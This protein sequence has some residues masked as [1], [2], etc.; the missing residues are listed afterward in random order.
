MTILLGD[1]CWNPEMC[2]LQKKKKWQTIRWPLWRRK[3]CFLKS[4]CFVL[5][6]FWG[7]VSISFGLC[8]QVGGKHLLV[9]FQSVNTAKTK[10]SSQLLAPYKHTCRHVMV[11]LHW[12]PTE[13]GAWGA[14]NVTSV[15]QKGT[16]SKGM[17]LAVV[18]QVFLV[19]FF[20]ARCLFS[21]SSGLNGTGAEFQNHSFLNW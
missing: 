3:Q 14:S 17:L 13:K 4:C 15:S 9:S 6:D 8:P 20:S 11:Q 2:S 21:H 7:S 16:Q 19:L 10:A 5:V 12:W 1:S 18:I